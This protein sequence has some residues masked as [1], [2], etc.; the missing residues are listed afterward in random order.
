MRYNLRR[1]ASYV[2]A[3]A[4]A[5]AAVAVSHLVAEYFATRRALIKNR[6]QGF[7][8]AGHLLKYRIQGLRCD[9]CRC[10]RCG[11][12]ATTLRQPLRRCGGMSRVESPLRLPVA[13]LVANEPVA[14]C[15]CDASKI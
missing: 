6:I 4:V 1:F 13:E 2:A 7:S 3:V 15:R 8:G 5:V 10:D 11:V 9:R 12:A 14:R